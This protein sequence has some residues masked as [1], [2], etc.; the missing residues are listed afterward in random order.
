MQAPQGARDDVSALARWLTL[1][2]SHGYGIFLGLGAAGRPAFAPAQHGTLVLGPPRCGKTAAIVVPNILGGC[3]PV[4]AVSTKPDLLRLTSAARSM[5]GDCLL[6]DP[7]GSVDVPR[8]VE[9]VAWSPLHAA[10]SW[11]GALSVA[12]AMVRASRPGGEHGDAVHWNERATALLSIAFHAGALGELPFGRVMEAVDRRQAGEF[13][14]RLATADAERSLQLLDGIMAT[15]AREQSG[16]W[17]TA[18]SVLAAYR[19]E[20]AIGSTVGTPLDASR[21]ASETSTLYVCAGS[22]EQRQ[23]APLVAGIL[24]DLRV[25]AY[26]RTASLGA[27]GSYEGPPMLFALDEVANI[28]PLHDLPTIVAEG[29]SQGVVTLACLQDLSQAKARW[30]READGFLSL[31]QAKVV[32]PGIGDITTLETISKLAGEID[33]PHTSRT[34]SPPWSALVG[35]RMQMSR[36]ESTRRQRRLPVDMIAQ[37]H[38]GVVLHLDGVRP[39]WLNATAWFAYSDLQAIVQP[40]AGRAVPDA[41]SRRTA[42]AHSSVGR[43]R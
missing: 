25:A 22:D 30:G 11:S 7:S 8:G 16:I 41:P 21:F 2:E 15:E 9:R 43:V 36:T 40:H 14:V 20:A 12:E 10:Q 38:P 33:V 1:S 28:A 23:A 3:G 35:Q 37:G 29:G 5:M 6:F 24:R 31:F 32:F 4:V 26:Q 39:Q 17:S 13:K 34:K 42:P 18:S 27:T 19:T